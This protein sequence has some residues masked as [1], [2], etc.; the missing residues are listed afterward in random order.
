[1]PARKYFTINLVNE[2][3]RNFSD[4]LVWQRP[5]FCAQFPFE[6]R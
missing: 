1:M 2:I 6:I 3:A 4:L 5:T